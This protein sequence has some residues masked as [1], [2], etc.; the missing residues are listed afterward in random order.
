MPFFQRPLSKVINVKKKVTLQ[1]RIPLKYYGLP[2]KRVLSS[3]SV[4]K[5]GAERRCV[6]ASLSVEA[7]LVLSLFLFA[8]AILMTP[9]KMMNDGRK[10]QT[11]LERVCEDACQYAGL[12]AA[13][14]EGGEDDSNNSAQTGS[15][16]ERV[17]GDLVKYM[18]KAGI[19]IYAERKIR[20]LA[21]VKKAG[22][23]SFSGTK[24]LDDGETVDLILH[25]QMYLPFPVFRIQGIPMTARS[26]RRAWIGK[27]G[28]TQSGDPGTDSM[29][30]TVY[31]GKG[32]T[33]YHRDKSCHYL[34]NNISAVSF[35]TIELLRN[36]D[37]KRYRPCARCGSLASAGSTVYVMPSGETY[38]SDRNCSSIVAYVRAVP[39][40]EVAS[41]GPCSYC[42]Q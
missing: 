34:F 31:V 3:A 32:S 12:K 25:Y 33:R 1:V 42:A 9:V 22:N 38:H 24:F 26:C 14:G 5:T 28:N 2:E 4:R 16:N 7:A 29:E 37:G 27:R 21:G 13:P 18:T 35:E 40:S 20:E 39:L 19:E 10:I 11:A 15:T 17:P 41:L 23:F 6:N 8:A 30:E 36:S